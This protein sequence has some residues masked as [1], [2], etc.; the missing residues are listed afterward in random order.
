M[1]R[2]RLVC[3]QAALL[4]EA[5][6]QHASGNPA[7]ADAGRRRPTRVRIRIVSKVTCV[8]D[9][10]VTIRCR[11]PGERHLLSLT[12]SIHPLIIGDPQ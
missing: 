4:A 5:P 3:R 7:Q 10:T 12:R 9:P 8:K 2:H 1:T 6:L 11:P